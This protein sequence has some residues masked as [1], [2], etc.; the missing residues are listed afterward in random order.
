VDLRQ[1]EPEAVGVNAARRSEVGA[2]TE[3]NLPPLAIAEGE[4]LDEI[5]LGVAVQVGEPLDLRR[6]KLGAA[7]G[8]ASALRAA[9]GVEALVRAARVR[10]H[11]ERM[12]IGEPDDKTGA[13]MGIGLRVG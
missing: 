10:R 8:V 7:A 9:I 5:G 4:E 1:P 12:F 3:A 6:V 13:V 2:T 11:S